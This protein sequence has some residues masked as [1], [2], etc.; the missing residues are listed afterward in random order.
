MY[1]YAIYEMKAE[2]GK[3]FLAYIFPDFANYTHRY[4]RLY[5][6]VYMKK[7]YK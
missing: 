6:Y 4:V 5:T 3:Y 7:K 1:M 2:V